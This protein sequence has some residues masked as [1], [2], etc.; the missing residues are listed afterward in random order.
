MNGTR[1]VALLL[2]ALLCGACASSATAITIPDQGF[3]AEV[4]AERPTGQSVQPVLVKYPSLDIAYV[5]NAAGDTYHFR[6]IF[7]TYFQDSW[8]YA[9]SLRGPW[10]FLEMKYAPSELFQVRGT[11]PPVVDS[12]AKVQLVSGRVER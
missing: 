11:R 4:P 12:G 7:Y 1:I 8:F 5:S 9:R 6:G 10:R 2:G 3:D